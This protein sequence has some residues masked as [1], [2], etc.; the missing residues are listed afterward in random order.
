MM[1]GHIRR[2]AHPRPSVLCLGCAL[3]VCAADY[4][5]SC[6]QAS[7]TLSPSFPVLCVLRPGI[8]RP[9]ARSPLRGVRVRIRGARDANGD[10]DGDGA[11]EGDGDGAGEGGVFQSESAAHS[12][13]GQRGPCPFSAGP[14]RSSTR[15]AEV[16]QGPHRYV[17]TA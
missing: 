16:R 4:G 7:A 3:D 6:R 11:G 12:A 15:P 9:Q 14:E 10:G 13:H 1:W 8:H 5:G 17:I 2:G